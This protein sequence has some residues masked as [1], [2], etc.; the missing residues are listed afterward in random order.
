[1]V[2]L[3]EIAK[4]TG[5]AESTISR[6]LN[7]DPSLSISDEKRRRVVETAEALQYVMRRARSGPDDDA[8][9]TLRRPADLKTVMIVHF[10]SSADELSQPFYVGLRQGIEARCEAYGLATTRLFAGEFDPAMLHRLRNVGVISVGDLPAEQRAAIEKL[11]I[12]LSLAHPHERPHDTD[13]AYVDLEAAS[14]RLSTWLLAR[15]VERP[16]FIG[17]SSPE[18]KRL[19][20][21]RKVMTEAGKFDA[22]YIGYGNNVRVDSDIHVDHLLARLDAAGKPRPDAIVVYADRVA[23]EVYRALAEARM[24]IPGDVQVVAFNDSS[25]ARMVA[26]KLTTLRLEAGVIGETA[27]D[28]LMER[29]GGRKA[30][31]HVEILPT[32]I[33]RGSTRKV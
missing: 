14:A 25:I 29:H 26:P 16:A 2:T 20:A 24:S 33:E 10:L 15:G 5:V 31:K 3:K 1:M 32:I 13:V 22:D 19:R 6:I 11:G 17:V 18:S 12:P 30:V 9:V 28:L 23:V 8:S 21:F 4:R 27:V 7:R